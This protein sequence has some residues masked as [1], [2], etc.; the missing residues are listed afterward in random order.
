MIR[1]G[2]VSYAE[3]PSDKSILPVVGTN[4]LVIKGVALTDFHRNPVISKEDGDKIL[5]AI[6]KN[7][8]LGSCSVVLIK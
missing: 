8:F 1:H 3:A 4:P 7:D 2:I 6:Q 5:G